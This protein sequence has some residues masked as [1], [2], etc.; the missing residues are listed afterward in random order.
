MQTDKCR[1]GKALG[2]G[3][4]GEVH[5]LKSPL[6][7]RAVVKSGKQGRLFT[8]ADLMWRM[9]HPNIATVLAKVLPHGT[10]RDSDLPGYIAIEALGE[11]LRKYDP[12][13]SAVTPSHHSCCMVL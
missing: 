7:P 4:Q 6:Y 10:A 2:E 13:R 9:R 3:V 11:P 1:L 8:E 12:T 5:E